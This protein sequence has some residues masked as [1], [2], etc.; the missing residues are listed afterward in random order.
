MILHLDVKKINFLDSKSKKLFSIK[1]IKYIDYR[2][3]EK[4]KEKRKNV[5]SDKSSNLIALP[6]F[7]INF[8]IL[9]VFFN[10]NNLPAIFLS[11]LLILVEITVFAGGFI[12][13]LEDLRKLSKKK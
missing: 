10:A 4:E 6:L 3:K 7:A 1:R 11:F 13:I 12:V 9:K 5:N 8:L 2:P